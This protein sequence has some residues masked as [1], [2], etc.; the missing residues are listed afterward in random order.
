MN[1]TE[2]RTNLEILG[3]TGQK[4]ATLLDHISHSSA[5]VKHSADEF[6]AT[7]HVCHLR[8]IEVEGYAFRIQRIINE[9]HPQLPDIDGGRLAFE[10]NYNQQDIRAA[11]ASFETA[12]RNNLETLMTLDSTQLERVGELEGL[13]TIKLGD[14]VSMLRE[15]D[16]AHLEELQAWRRRLCN[17]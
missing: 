2:F 14:L 10:R 9:D 11:L 7:E 15:H 6:S 5:Q 17:P 12:R 3:Q 1:L 13:G 16:E 4:L 8:D